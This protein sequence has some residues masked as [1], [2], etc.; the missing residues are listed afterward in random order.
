MKPTI[1]EICETVKRHPKMVK[2]CYVFGSRV[3]GTSTEDSD[4]DIILIANASSPEVEHKTGNLNVHI[5][6]PDRFAKELKDNH[7]RAIECLCAPDWAVLKPFPGIDSFAYRPESFRHN[8]SHTVSNSWVKAKKK[9]EQGDYYIGVKSIFHSLR[10]ADFGT[11][12]ATTKKITYSSMNVVWTDIASREWTW[13]ELKEKY[14]PLRNLLLTEFRKH[15][16][17]EKL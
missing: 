12:F 14:Q 17:K 3:Y 10:L 5:L 1:E 15:T 2:G 11:Q 16:E 8:I 4:W 9:L 7:I 13:E 6:T